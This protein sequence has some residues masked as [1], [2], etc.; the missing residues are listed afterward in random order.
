M[1]LRCITSIGILI[2]LIW[3]IIGFSP[4]IPSTKADSF[5]DFQ[6]IGLASMQFFPEK[7][8]RSL[9]KIAKWTFER[10]R[11]L[12]REIINTLRKEKQVRAFA[13]FLRL[14]EDKVLSPDAQNAQAL[15]TFHSNADRDSYRYLNEIARLNQVRLIVF[16]S[17][18]QYIV[19]DYINSSYQGD[20][21]I[22][23]NIYYPEMSA[24]QQEPILITPQMIKSRTTVALRELIRNACAKTLKDAIDDKSTLF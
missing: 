14:G 11:S 3:S 16:S 7:R 18:D 9:Q 13:T 5:K 15:Q 24:F 20:I 12:M 23:I 17:I 10:Q 22:S 8:N 21:E 2:L 4:I 6:G 19:E 1:I